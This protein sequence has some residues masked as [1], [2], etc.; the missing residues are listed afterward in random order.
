[1]GRVICPRVRFNGAWDA[2][3]VYKPAHAILLLP[4]VLF[5]SP[6]RPSS[7]TYRVA[8][9]RVN[10]I[11]RLPEDRRIGLCF[12]LSWIAFVSRVDYK[13]LFKAI[14]G[15]TATLNH[16][17]Q[18]QSYLLLLTRRATSRYRPMSYV[19]AIACGG[20]P[21]HAPSEVEVLKES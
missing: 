2:M 19:S 16:L 13:C 20:A 14:G 9:E 10:T 11:V 7:N 8:V 3:P 4:T 6:A 1:M 18:H 21:H 5:A 12:I 15:Q 17:S